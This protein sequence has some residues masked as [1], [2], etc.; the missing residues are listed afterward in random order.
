MLFR[1]LVLGAVS[2]SDEGSYSVTVT[3]AL[4]SVTS[5]AASLIVVG[6]PAITTQPGAASVAEGNTATFSVAASGNSLRYQWLRD[7]TTITGA[8]ASSYTTGNL[9]LSDNGAAFSV[10][11]YNAAGV[12]FSQSA[13]LTVTAA[14]PA[15]LTAKAVATGYGSSFAVD[16]DGTVWAWGY[17]VDPATGGYKASSPW[18]TQPVKVQG[19]SGVKSITAVSESGAFYAL[20]DDGTVSAWGRNDVGQLGDGTTTTQIGRAHV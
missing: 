12:V 11:V 13:T 15:G 3:N 5:N 14:A 7:G 16:P 20:H 17:L 1:S 19:L 2:A 8:T 9:S 4:G 18:A 6:A 10:L